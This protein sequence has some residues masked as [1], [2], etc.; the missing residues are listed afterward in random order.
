MAFNEELIKGVSAIYKYVFE[1]PNVHRNV[2][3]KQMINK[4][5]VASKEKFSKI[6]E[7]LLALDKLS[8]QG[9][10][11][12]INPRMLSVGVLQK[13]GDNFYI[14]TSNSNKHLNVSRSVASGYNVGDVLDLVV[15]HNGKRIES[16]Y[17]W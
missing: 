12:S 15:E 16:C 9:E 8:M 2:L 4:G 3:R 6:L 13:S 7:S 14:V 11:V 1:N 10:L 17:S 5:K